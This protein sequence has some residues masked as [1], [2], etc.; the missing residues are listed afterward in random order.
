MANYTFSSSTFMSLSTIN[1]QLSP[2]PG[3]SQL[4]A[5]LAVGSTVC[6]VKKQS[7]N[8]CLGERKYHGGHQ[9]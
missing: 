7:K 9:Y 2:D 8:K 5:R 6:Q 4:A 3:I 1:M